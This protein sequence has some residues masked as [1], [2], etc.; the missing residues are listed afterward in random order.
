MPTAEIDTGPSAFRDVCII[1]GVRV[2]GVVDVQVK[3]SRKVERKSPKGGG[4][5]RMTDNG[6]P[7]AEVSI[8][9]QLWTAVHRAEFYSTLLP[10]ISPRTPDGP[11]NPVAI[12]H[13]KTA[14][15]GV[16]DIYIEGI[17]DGN[18]SGGVQTIR[19]NAPEWLP[20][21]KPV[22]KAPGG[23][24]P[25]EE[26]TDNY[27]EDIED[28]RFAADTADSGLDVNDGSRESLHAFLD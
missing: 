3:Q 14:F 20:G 8:T 24:P 10:K 2:P 28:S 25:S 9:V 16:K 26:E 21:P 17:E 1:A 12:E 27:D 22:K 13:W 4:G 6:Y 11:K 23:K 18:E 5:A 7:G 15:Y 19:L